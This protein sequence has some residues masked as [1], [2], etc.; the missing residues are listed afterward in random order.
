MALIR[1]RQ[2]RQMFSSQFLKWA[3]RTKLRSV[4]KLDRFWEFNSRLFYPHTQDKL[5][6]L[7]TS[8][9]TLHGIYFQKEDKLFLLP[10]TAITLLAKANPAPT[11]SETPRPRRKKK[12]QS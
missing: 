4:V 3:I 11:I 2:P 6:T 5:L 7:L 1:V 9:S 12:H 10:K 8:S